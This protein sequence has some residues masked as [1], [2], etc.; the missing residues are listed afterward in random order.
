LLVRL[1][2]CLLVLPWLT[3]LAQPANA[4]GGAAAGWFH[5]AFNPAPAMLAVGF[6]RPLAAPPA[7][8][9]PGEAQSDEPGRPGRLDAAGLD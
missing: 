8:L 1:L 2:G 5:S 9:V 6:P 7:G 4:L 3:A